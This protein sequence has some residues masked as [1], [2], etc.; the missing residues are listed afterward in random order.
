MTKTTTIDAETF[1]AA[2]ADFATAGIERDNMPVCQ[3]SL[4]AMCTERGRLSF[5]LAMLA[6]ASEG[7]TRLD[8]ESTSMR[9]DMGVKSNRIETALALLLL[10]EVQ[11]PE[12]P[13]VPAIPAAKLSA[14]LDRTN[15]WVRDAA[16]QLLAA[17]Q[18]SAAVIA[19]HVLAWSAAQ[20]VAARDWSQAFENSGFGATPG[21]ARACAGDAR[22]GRA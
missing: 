15:G 5:A 1:H 7:L 21:G 8:F 3:L 11:E 18:C 20:I 9:T 10:F 22:R 17:T 4:Q 16:L 12:E 2:V 19:D 13:A 6:D 14:L